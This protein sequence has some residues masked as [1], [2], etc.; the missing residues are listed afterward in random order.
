[1]CCWMENLIVNYVK[2]LSANLVAAGEAL[3]AS[4]VVYIAQSIVPCSEQRPGRRLRENQTYN[5]ALGK[6][7]AAMRLRANWPS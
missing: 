1:M 4:Q 7:A 2:K 6:S 5:S 3:K